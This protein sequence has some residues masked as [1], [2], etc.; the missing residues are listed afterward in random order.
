MARQRGEPHPV[1]HTPDHSRAVVAARDDEGAVLAERRTRHGTAVLEFQHGAVG[2]PQPR[3]TVGACTEHELAVRAVADCG[4]WENVGAEASR[5]AGRP[6]SRSVDIG[7]PDPGEAVI[8]GRDYT[9]TI[10][11]ERR[12]WHR[13]AAPEQGGLRQAVRAPRDE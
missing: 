5:P 7:V 6:G 2:T 9:S 8:A 11:T 10:R 12:I 4:D 13:P 3:G 1:A